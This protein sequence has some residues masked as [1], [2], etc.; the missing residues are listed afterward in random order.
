MYQIKTKTEKNSNINN[1]IDY[2][3]LVHEAPIDN[4]IIKGLTDF[5]FSPIKLDGVFKDVFR[6]NNS[7][8]VFSNLTKPT[9]AAFEFSGESR[10]LTGV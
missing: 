1:L 3:L 6:K 5:L 9:M 8:K 7:K 4:L 2:Q 10:P